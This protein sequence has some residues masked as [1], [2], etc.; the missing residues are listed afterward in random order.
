M[1]IALASV[2]LLTGS[3]Q[4]MQTKQANDT[5]PSLYN[6]VINP[7]VPQNSNEQLRLA[8]DQHCKNNSETGV[9]RCTTNS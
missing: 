8:K 2:V 7:S 4:A 9:V 6:S 3:A 1:L 5:T